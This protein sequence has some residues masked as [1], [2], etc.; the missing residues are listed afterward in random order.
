MSGSG[1]SVLLRPRSEPLRRAHP[2]RYEPVG[3]VPLEDLRLYREL[4]PPQHT[5][6]GA[7]A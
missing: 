5:G 1:A 3:L 6:L 4:L 7:R 2:V